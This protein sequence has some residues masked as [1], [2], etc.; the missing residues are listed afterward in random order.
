MSG[1]GGRSGGRG[2]HNSRGRGRGHSS[3]S[4]SAKK[5][6]APTKKTLAD[7]IYT[8]GSAKQASEF[9]TNTKFIL[10]HLAISTRDGNDIATA[11]RNKEEM[12]F[13]TLMPTLKVSQSTDDAV[14]ASEEAQFKILFEAEVKAYVE[15]QERHRANKNMA[16]A[17]IWKQCNK[18]LQAKLQARTGFHD[19][20]EGNPIEL[21]KAVPQ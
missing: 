19:A 7:H 11:L 1:R 10:N 9:Q 14:K 16:Y 20:I 2:R 3:G 13:D 6:P 18:A 12:D 17:L 5:A 4:G 8:I 15:R 21:L